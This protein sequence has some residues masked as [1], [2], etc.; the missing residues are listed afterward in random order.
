M[1]FLKKIVAISRV[2][3][4]V[5][6]LG[7]LVYNCASIPR[8]SQENKQTIKEVLNSPLP[9]TV[10]GETGFALNN[11]N[12]IWY[13]R[14]PVPSG[15]KG[16]VLLI[17]G[18]GQDALSWPP[19]FISNFTDAGYEVVR[20]DHR[21]TGLSEYGEKWKKKDPYTLND[22]AGDALA[23][24]DTLK[25][26]KAHLVGA[27]MG[28]IIA[29]V[30]A[31][32]HPERTLT[33]TSIMSSGDVT[34]PDLPP[35][36]DEVL[37]KM[38]SAVLSHG[39][40]GSKKG[41]IKR[42]IVQKKILMG[43]ATGDIDVETLA[44]TALYNLEKREGYDLTAAR[45]HFAAIQESESRIDALTELKVPTLVIHGIQDPVIP[46]EHG[47]KLARTISDSDSLWVENMGHDLPDGSID[48]ICE[49][50]ILNFR[51]SEE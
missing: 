46:I 47:K 28:G 18:N 22:M 36:S 10:K 17:M 29:Q 34:D 40:L 19:D 2:F 48:T 51:R 8:L 41:Q 6:L 11:G 37:P 15:P 14:M 23:V 43:K 31:L 30:I 3:L 4:P 24:L 1:G 39:F 50:I 5:V 26:R 25:I 42:Q 16:S 32:D 49:K 38:I 35:M 44:E 12:R 9:E 21:G 7:I 33:L 13:E 45:H 27:S 20:F